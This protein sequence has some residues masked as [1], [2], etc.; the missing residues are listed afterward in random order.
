[1]TLQKCPDCGGSMLTSGYAHSTSC[2]WLVPFRPAGYPLY[3][4]I[5]TTDPTVSEHVPRLAAPT[6]GVKMTQRSDRKPSRWCEFLL[7]GFTHGT[8]CGEPTEYAYPA[9]G[10]GWMALCGIHAEKFHPTANLIG[11]RHISEILDDIR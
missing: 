8:T 4:S 7:D 9:S 6:Q 3:V 1:M 10:G 2:P 5:T 11:M